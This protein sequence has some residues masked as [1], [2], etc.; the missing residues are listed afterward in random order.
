MPITSISS[1]WYPVKEWEPAKRFYS[2][3]L[4]LSAIAR[5]DETGWAAFSAGEASPPVFLVRKP[6]A[7]GRGGAVVTFD[8][9]DAEAMLERIGAF[10]AKVDAHIQEGDAVRI[11]TVYDPDGNAVEL[12][13]T[14]GGG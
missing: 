14:V 2:E 11:Y 7:E 1:V 6:A 8:V 5:N 9:T 4:G 3:A 12:S 10:G 13:E